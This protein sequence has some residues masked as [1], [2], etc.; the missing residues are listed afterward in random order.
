MDESFFK[1]HWLNNDVGVYLVQ[2]SLL[3]LVSRVWD[4]S[5]DIGPCFTNA[6]GKQ[7]ILRQ[8]LFVQYRLQA[9]PL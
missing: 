8:L 5:L 6:G 7:P 3:L 2:V 4:M 9:S 1:L